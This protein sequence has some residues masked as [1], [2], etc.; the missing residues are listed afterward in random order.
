MASIFISYRRTDGGYAGRIFDGL[1]RA[2]GNSSVFRDVDAIRDGTKFPEAIRHQLQSCRVFILVIGPGWHLA[3]K[4]DGTDRLNDPEDWVRLEI[5][6]ALK[7]TACFIPITVGGARLPL[8]HNLPEDLKTLAERQARELRDGD[9]WDGDMALLIRRIASEL[10]GRSR[11]I[12][13]YGLPAASALVLIGGLILLAPKFLTQRAPVTRA[14]FTSAPIIIFENGNKENVQNRP[15]APTKFSIKQPHF[16]THIYTYHWNNGNGSTPG[17]IRLQSGDG[18]VFGPWEARGT[19]GHN[20][21]Q[22]V[23]WVVE[24]NREIPAGDYTVVDSEPSTWSQNISSGSAGF[25]TLM[26]F[27]VNE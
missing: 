2:F 25:A 9:T 6:T 4:E 27:P 5:A 24:P 15:V 10:G 3:R 18:K 23:N 19:S 8:S 20:N 26:G 16:V 12:T 14:S 21:A 1:Q 7:R 13:R 11:M 22:N 17:R